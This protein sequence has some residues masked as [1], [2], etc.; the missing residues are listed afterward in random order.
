MSFDDVEKVLTNNR[1]SICMFSVDDYM[2]EF[3]DYVLDEKD[4]GEE[5]E[6]WIVGNYITPIPH[7]NFMIDEEI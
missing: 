5:N 4:D 7:L 2:F 6:H 3:V 1:S